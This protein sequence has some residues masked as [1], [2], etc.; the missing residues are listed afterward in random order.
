MQFA[1][2][3]NHFKLLQNVYQIIAEIYLIIRYH[4]PSAIKCF[5][6]LAPRSMA[7]GLDQGHS[8]RWAFFAS[9][10]T[11][12][13]GFAFIRSFIH[14]PSELN[15]CTLLNC[16]ED[17]VRS[18]YLLISLTF[19]YTSR[20]SVESSAPTILRSRIWIPSTTPK[21]NFDSS[22]YIFAVWM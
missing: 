1:D 6:S 11:S 22:N 4:L 15:E 16:L 17:D 8:T 9:S 14:H 13:V 3:K 2:V 21:L 10:T 20:S 5:T 18:R 7:H 19:T 12:M